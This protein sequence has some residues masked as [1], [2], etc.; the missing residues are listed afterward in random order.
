MEATDEDDHVVQDAIEE[1]VREST[2]ER[3]AYRGG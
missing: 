2:N 3:D 1:A